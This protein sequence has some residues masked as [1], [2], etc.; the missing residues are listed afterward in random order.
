MKGFIDHWAAAV[1]LFFILFTASCSLPNL[2]E[3]E[4]VESRDAVKQFYSFHLANDMKPSL[5]NF[6]ARERFLT[7]ELAVSLRTSHLTEFDPFT[8]TGDYPK[9]FRV[10]ECKVPAPG[11]TRLQVILFWRDDNRSEQKEVTVDAVRQGDK[12]LIDNVVGK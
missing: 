2:E 4:C 8:A 3:S 10:G 1:S 11:K 9:A 7:K 6:S 5:E 12:W